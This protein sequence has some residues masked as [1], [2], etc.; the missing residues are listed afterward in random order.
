MK[1][2]KEIRHP[3]T[4]KWLEQQINVTNTYYQQEGICFCDKKPTP[5]CVLKSE[6]AQISNA[7]FETKS[8]TDYYG[9]YQG[10]YFDFDAKMVS[11]DSFNVKKI[12]KP[13]QLNHLLTIKKHGGDAFI[14][15]YFSDYD[16]YYL[17]DIDD[18]ISNKTIHL[19]QIEDKYKI[20][21]LVPGI[22]DYL[23]TY[24]EVY[25]IR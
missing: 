12:V 23:S 13:H 25:A 8:T 20:N 16:Y 21:L 11:G 6:G 14:I 22:I 3:T 24:K 10:H 2:I 18:L 15:A 1:N 9:L 7:F 4:G 17:L 19:E 5:I